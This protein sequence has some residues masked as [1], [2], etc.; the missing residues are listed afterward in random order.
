MANHTRRKEA[1]QAAKEAKRGK[2]FAAS[3]RWAR[4]GAEKVRLVADQIRDLPINKAL[5]ILKFTKKRGGYLL[6]KVVK[7]ALANAEYQ[8][9]ELKLDLDID[10]LYVADVHVDEGPT[11]KRWMTRSRGMAYPILRRFCHINATLAPGK[12]KGGAEEAAPAETA[13]GAAEKPAKKK[14]AAKAATAG[15][16]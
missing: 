14:K 5:N 7:T 12:G 3:H 11:M 2:E 9:S 15:A 6:G 16:K 1:H 10:S 4:I 8:I 13:K